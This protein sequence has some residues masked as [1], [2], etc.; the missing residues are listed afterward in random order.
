MNNLQIITNHHWRNLSYRYEVPEKVLKDQFDY[1][2]DEFGGFLK[3]R[4]H[5]YHL[6]DFMTTSANSPFPD[7]QGYASDSFFSGV[8]ID[9]SEDCEQYRIA[10][11]IG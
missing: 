10:T 7:W 1:I 11:Y 9:L 4:N 3:Y 8:L 6:T 5:W 2:P